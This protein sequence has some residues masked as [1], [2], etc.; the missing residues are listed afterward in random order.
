MNDLADFMA[1]SEDY[2]NLGGSVQSQLR[3]VFHGEPLD[4]QN[5][6]ALSYAL[7][8]LKDHFPDE[9]LTEEIEAYLTEGE[10]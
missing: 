4:E 3:S 1:I 8:F 2:D 5:R 10:Q 9:P 6:N 7:N